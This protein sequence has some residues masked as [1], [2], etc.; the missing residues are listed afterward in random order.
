[1]NLETILSKNTVQ[2]QFKP[3]IDKPPNAGLLTQTIV[4]SPISR[5]ILPVRLGNDDDNDVAFIGVS[6]NLLV[7]SIYASFEVRA[8]DGLIFSQQ[9][10][11]FSHT[12]AVFHSQLFNSIVSVIH[13]LT[14]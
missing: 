2:E 12:E 1:M 7:D 5:W 11:H 6:T 3:D 4:Q 10:K 14:G 8:E 9:P 13:K